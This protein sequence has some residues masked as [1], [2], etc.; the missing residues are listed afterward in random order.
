[1]T[2]SLFGCPATFRR[3][4]GFK[5]FISFSDPCRTLAFLQGLFADDFFGHPGVNSEYV[6][7]FHDIDGVQANLTVYAGYR[8]NWGSLNEDA[9]QFVEA[10]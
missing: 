1:M 10:H 6:Q 5:L 7:S 9:E 4:L 2:A 3:L 8:L